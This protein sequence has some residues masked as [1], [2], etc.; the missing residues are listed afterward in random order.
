[1]TLTARFAVEFVRSFPSPLVP[2]ILYVSTEYSTAGHLCPCGCG[3]EVVTKLSPARYRVTFDGEISLA[4]SVAATGLNCNSHYFITRGEVD[5][6][7]RLDAAQT[8]RARS[9]DRQA[10][11]EQRVP[12]TRTFLGRLMGVIRRRRS[13]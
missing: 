10:I 7:R 3:G 4:P 9:V 8:E 13:T 5:W 12:Q 2:G 1:M 11:E 6:H